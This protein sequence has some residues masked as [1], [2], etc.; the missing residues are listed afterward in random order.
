M[1]Q[2]Q[3]HQFGELPDTAR[4]DA[5]EHWVIVDQGARGQSRNGRHFP[6]ATSCKNAISGCSRTVMT[7]RRCC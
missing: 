6:T 4:F 1:K 7:A 3:L 2:T 5:L